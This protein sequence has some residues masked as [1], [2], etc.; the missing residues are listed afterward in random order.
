MSKTLFIDHRQAAD[1]IE[2]YALEGRLAQG[3]WRVAAGDGG[4]EMACL[5]AAMHEDIA[6]VEA[7]PP[8]IMPPWLAA[9]TVRLFDALPDARLYPL[10][11]SFTKSLR[12]LA[13]STTRAGSG[14]AEPSSAGPRTSPFPAK[15]RRLAIRRLPSGQHCV[16]RRVLAAVL[17]ARPGGGPATTPSKRRRRRW[18]RRPGAPLTPRAPRTRRRGTKPPLSTRRRTLRRRAR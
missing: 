17:A 6:S 13:G 16:R 12:R 4:E 5:L 15:R 10:V 1:N 2:A 7:C 9:L 11:A 3:A 18:R 8:W 14:C